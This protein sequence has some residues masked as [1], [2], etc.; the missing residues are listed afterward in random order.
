LASD[1]Q[2]RNYNFA[3]SNA[4]AASRPPNCRGQTVV[5]ELASA[6]VAAH[7]RR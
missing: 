2:L 1:L 6:I 3:I 4:G 7:P 5:E